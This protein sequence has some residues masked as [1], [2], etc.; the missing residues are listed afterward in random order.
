MVI[1]NFLSDPN[2]DNLYNDLVSASAEAGV[3]ETD[4]A[5]VTEK[6][7]SENKPAIAIDRDG[8][9]LGCPSVSKEEAIRASGELLMAHG[10]VDESYIDAMFERERVQSVYMGLGVAI[11][12]GT[13]DAKDSVKKTC[14]TLHQYPDGVDWGEEKAYLVFGIAGAGGE[15]LTVLANV[16]RALEDDTVIAKMRTTDDVDWLLKVLS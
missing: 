6:I 1:N 13:N 4:V 9:K 10:A 7:E 2:L 5:V 8:I 14:V 12:H 3:G 16:A 11:P 15:H